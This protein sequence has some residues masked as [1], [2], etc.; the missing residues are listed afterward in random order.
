MKKGTCRVIY[1][2]KEDSY[3]LELKN[4]G[5]KEWGLVMIAKC[6]PDKNGDPTMIHYTF[7]TEL[8]QTV[9]AGYALFD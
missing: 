9:S 6:Q 3:R 1:D 7:L 8:L 2:K 4:T 5:E